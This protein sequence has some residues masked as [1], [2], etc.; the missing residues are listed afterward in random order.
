MPRAL[1][2]GDRPELGSG[3][4]LPAD[5]FDLVPTASPCWE[6]AWEGCAAACQ[7]CPA[8]A[9]AARQFASRGAEGLTKTSVALC[10][11]RSRQAPHTSAT[12]Q[13]PELPAWHAD[14]WRRR[15]ESRHLGLYPLTLWH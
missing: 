5:S 9:I 13:N 1:P 8:A 4:A 15:R 14:C 12:L 10:G 7:L 2:G 6:A 3:E 11:R